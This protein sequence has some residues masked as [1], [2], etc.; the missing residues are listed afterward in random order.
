MKEMPAVTLSE[1]EQGDV[2]KLPK[3]PSVGRREEGEE[4]YHGIKQ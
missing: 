4:N 3:R 2:R 1:C